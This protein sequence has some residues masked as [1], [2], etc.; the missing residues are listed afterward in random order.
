[1]LSFCR[2]LVGRRQLPCYGGIILVWLSRL[3]TGTA[4]A[5]ADSSSTR[6]TMRSRNCF[7]E[8]LLPEFAPYALIGQEWRDDQWHPF[9]FCLSE[10]RDAFRRRHV[11][12]WIRA[13]VLSPGLSGTDEKRL[14]F[15]VLVQPGREWQGR[16]TDSSIA[17]VDRIRHMQTGEERRQP[18]YRRIFDRLRRAIRKRLVVRSL[19]TLPSGETQES[20][21]MTARAADAHARGEVSFDVEPIGLKICRSLFSR[22]RASVGL[23]RLSSPS[24]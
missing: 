21:S 8:M 23:A 9:E 10:A 6:R 11:N 15:S 1:M 19:R 22:G 14:S 5:G 12:Y 18:E 7:E 4:L 13:H 20:F 3:M 17:V 24:P 2:V 16:I